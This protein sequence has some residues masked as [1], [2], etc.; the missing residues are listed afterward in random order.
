MLRPV[1]PIAELLS[2]HGAQPA[3]ATPLERTARSLR[4]RC[5]R[6][7]REFAAFFDAG[8]GERLAVDPGGHERQVD[9]GPFLRAMEPDRSYL[10]FHTHPTSTPF[11]D[12]DGLALVL[13]A[14]IRS[15]IV[16]GVDG[17]WYAMSKSTSEAFG[18]DRAAEMLTRFR[19]NLG[20]R[21]VYYLQRVRSGHMGDPE[22]LTAAMHEAW[23]ATA[24][25]FGLRY[26]R[27]EL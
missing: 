10:G 16:L 22:G 25:R 6:E 17:T 18:L 14:G 4:R 23:S 20:E 2:R 26:E 11:S 13:N 9:L 3:V 19:G 12:A 7:G 21:A 15:I 5:E 24:P 27:L 1:S 8:T